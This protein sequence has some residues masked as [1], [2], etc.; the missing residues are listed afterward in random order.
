MF[1]KI[2]DWFRGRVLV[3]V[4]GLSPERF[5]NLCA[6]N[7][8]VLRELKK[9]G[10]GYECIM[11]LPEYRKARRLAKKAKA[12]L[13]IQRKI[14]LPFFLF[15]QRKRKAFAAGFLLAIGLLYAASL[16]LW[17]VQVEGNGHY[18]DDIIRSF[19]KENGIHY[20]MRMDSIVCE[21]IEKALRN[22]YT[23]ITWVSAQISGV[24]LKIQVKE[25]FGLLKAP[26]KDLTPK[27]VVAD[28]DGV[29]TEII[30]RSGVPKATAG[31]TV[32]QGQVL[33]SGRIPLIG[34]SGETIGYEEVPADGTIVARTEVP[35]T[36]QRSIFEETRRVTKTRLKGLAFNVFGNRAAVGGGPQA[37]EMQYRITEYHTPCLFDNFLLPLTLESTFE[38]TYETEL[39]KLTKEEQQKKAEEAFFEQEALWKEEG[40]T[41]VEK[42]LQILEEPFQLTVTGTVT[43]EGPLGQESPLEALP[44]GETLPGEED[45]EE[46]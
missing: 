2:I 22:E 29:I 31:D 16:F 32:T 7:G 25:N 35:Y 28:K 36:W 38:Y 43:L 33:I 18:T 4:S 26:E 9:T 23:N 17:D 1:R 24:K 37:G 15:R 44:E 5:L 27:D 21:E 34:D 14:G 11:S 6:G 8:F 42:Q 13:R 12:T 19:L 46:S 3:R 45:A 41:V 39:R 20:G 10:E 40:F 30:T